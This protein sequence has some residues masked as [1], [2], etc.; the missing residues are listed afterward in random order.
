MSGDSGQHPIAT[1]AASHANRVHTMSEGKPQK[2][3]LS[4]FQD[5]CASCVKTSFSD[6]DG[7][8][9]HEIKDK[10]SKLAQVT[11]DPEMKSKVQQLSGALERLD[12]WQLRSWPEIQRCVQTVFDAKHAQQ[13]SSDHDHVTLSHQPLAQIQAVDATQRVVKTSRMADED[14][15]M[16]DSREKEASETTF[17]KR[18]KRFLRG[19]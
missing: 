8:R 7:L 6:K 19:K 12:A 2:S 13:Q 17:I 4:D 1:E 5:T 16:A 11:T 15:A 9:L 14:S 10:L 3:P 18:L